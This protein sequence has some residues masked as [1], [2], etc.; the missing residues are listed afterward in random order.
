MDPSDPVVCPLMMLVPSLLQRKCSL[1]STT[2]SFEESGR[3]DQRP[4][5]LDEKAT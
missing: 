5:L 4:V 2:L 1:N 3:V